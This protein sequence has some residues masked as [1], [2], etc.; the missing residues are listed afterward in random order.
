MKTNKLFSL[1]TIAVLVVTLTGCPGHM[2]SSSDTSVAAYI[3]SPADEVYTRFYRVPDGKLEK[4]EFTLSPSSTVQVI[5][6][7]NGENLI[8]NWE[9]DSEYNDL[10]VQKK[11]N[12]TNTYVLR[13]AYVVLNG[14]TVVWE[15]FPSRYAQ[16]EQTNGLPYIEQ[17]ID[18]LLVHCPNSV[19]VIDDMQEHSIYNDKAGSAPP[20]ITINE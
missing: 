7:F 2:P 8:V 6:W 20:S 5:K 11:S 1:L 15:Y 4:H 10:H 19:V 13:S 17:V 9:Y 16:T 14:Q 3:Y 18:S 12:N